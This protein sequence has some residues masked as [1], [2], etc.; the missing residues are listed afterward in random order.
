MASEIVR[1]ET[2]NG[3]AVQVTEQDVRDLLQAGGQ[4]ADNVSASEIK[5]FLRLCQAQ[6]LNPF[7]RDAYIVKYGSSPATIITGKEAF[8]KR[9]SRNPRYR[10]MQAGITVLGRDGGLH[11]RDGSMLLDGEALAGGWCKVFVE[12]YENPMFEEVS[13]REYSTGKGNWARIPATMIRKV[14]ITHALREAFPE[15]LAGLYGEEE[16]SRAS[17]PQQSPVPIDGG[18]Y[19]APRPARAPLQAEVVDVQPSPAPQPQQP[20]DDALA[21]LRA[22][23]SEAK[24][25]GVVIDDP[26]QPMN[27]M[28]GWVRA[29]FGGREPGQLQPHELAVAERYARKIVDERRAAQARQQAEQEAEYQ[30][31]L[32]EAAGAYEAE[33]AAQAARQDQGAYEVSEYDIEF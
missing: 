16:M 21:T 17:E 31:T 11:R 12:G 9:A 18:Y 3:T 26:A 23:F 1:Y 24:S 8:T 4:A 14:A 28:M 13:F 7:T 19:A 2:D 10:G 15:D 6:R 33:A 27:G 5:A 25:M 32:D 20:A 30:M 22:L 29:T